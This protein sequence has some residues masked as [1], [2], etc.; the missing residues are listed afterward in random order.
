MA[1]KKTSTTGAATPPKP[2]VRPTLAQQQQKSNPSGQMVTVDLV[3]DKKGS[4]RVG[5]N[6]RGSI[7]SRR[8]PINQAKAFMNSIQR[9]YGTLVNIPEI[10]AGF[11]LTSTAQARL[12][13]QGIKEESIEEVVEVASPKSEEIV[14]SDIKPE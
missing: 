3:Q 5:M 8:L 6:V 7:A 12:T 2:L 10:P 14:D 1:K 4:L 13:Q 11:R 9:K